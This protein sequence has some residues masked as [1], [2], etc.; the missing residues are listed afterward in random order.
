MF[1]NILYFA[2]RPTGFGFEWQGMAGVSVELSEVCSEITTLTG[3][4]ATR[5]NCLYQCEV[6][7][8]TGILEVA[9][10]YLTIHQCTLS[11]EYIDGRQVHS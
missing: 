4:N 3:E 2:E 10:R 1:K 8:V 9:F 6:S 5:L 11:T 7:T